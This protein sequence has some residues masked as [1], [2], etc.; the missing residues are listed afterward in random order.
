MTYSKIVLCGLRCT[1][2]TTLFWNLQKQLAWPTFSV[3]Q[4][5]RDYIRTYHVSP[6][7]VEQDS[8]KITTDI[9]QRIQS[10]LTSPDHVIIESRVFYLLRQSI[11]QTLKLL[12]TASDNVRIKRSSEREQT[13][14]IK[15]KTRL[16]KRETE[17]TQRMGQIYGFSD[18]FNPNYYDLVINTDLL[19][20][21]QV[22]AQ[23]LQYLHLSSKTPTHK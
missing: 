21:D 17:F 4:Y 13:D 6:Y 11:P 12:L 22:T 3:S 8:H 19:T 10:L 9:D 1:G 15:A 18:F 5:L 23:V 7:Q 2:K 20:P 16:D 14:L